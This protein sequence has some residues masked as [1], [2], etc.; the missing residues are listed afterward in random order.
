MRLFFASLTGNVRK[1]ST[2]LPRKILTTCEDLEQVFLQRWGVMEDMA[3]LY[4]Q[5]LN[6][7]KQN[8]ETVREFNDRFNT[9]LSRIDSDFL[10][11]STILRQYLNSFK[12]NFQFILRNRFPTN[13]KEAQDGA[14]RIEENIKWCDPIPQ[15]QDD[16]LWFNEEEVEEEEHDF[17]EILEVNDEIKLTIP[18]KGDG[19]WKNGLSTMKDA[20]IFSKQHEPSKDIGTFEEITKLERS[21]SQTQKPLSMRLP[22]TIKPHAPKEQICSNTLNLQNVARQEDDPKSLSC[23]D[24]HFER[25]HPKATHEKSNYVDSIFTLF[26]PNQIQE[27]QDMRKPRIECLGQTS[28]DSRV[29]LEEPQVYVGDLPQHFPKPSNDRTNL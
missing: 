12:G 6:I 2:K 8:H 13:L 15:D 24:S 7:C 23:K 22:Q 27:N 11:E 28:E 19:T 14:C 5:Y 1:W 3:S 18:P 26:T 16:V 10:P 4:S 21:L 20:L 9:L 25:Y 17:P 29:K